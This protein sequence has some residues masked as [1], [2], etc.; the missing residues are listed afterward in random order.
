[1]I[2]GIASDLSS[3]KSLKL[4]PGLNILLAD[5]SA[6]ATDRQ[7]R[8][9]VGKTSLVELVH[10]VLGGKS[11]KENIFRSP[12]LEEWS[13]GLDIDVAAARVTAARRGKKASII[14]ID[15]HASTWP[16]KPS[17]NEYSGFQELENEDWKT[18][19]GHVWFGLPARREN[20]EKARFEPSFRSLFSYFAR[21]QSAG[22]FVDPIRNAEK[23]QSWDQQVSISYLLG[24]DWTISQRLQELRGQERMAGELRKAAKGGELGR[25]FEKAADLRTK[26][27]VAQAKALRLQEQIRSF[28][29]VPQYEA[30][31]REA[32]EL[33]RV[34]SMLSDE[35]VIDRQLVNELRTSLDAEAEPAT[36][37]LAA[38]YDEAGVVLPSAV[39]KRYSDV[40]A[41][42]RAILANRKAHLSAEIQ[43]A[44]ARIA[45]R[46]V[47]QAKHDKRRAE[48]MEILNAGGALDSYI[49]LS[50]EAGRMEA[51]VQ[52]LR[53]RLEAAERLETTKADL[54]V[55]RAQ[56]AQSLKND[57][58]E[59]AEIISEA[60]L[61]FE[62]L[63]DALYEKEGSLTIAESN[64]GPVFEVKI[65][66]QRSKG[67]NNMQIFCF[68]MMLSILGKK[69]NRS[70]GFLIH[71]SHLFD[72]VDERQTARALQI[73]AE[74]SRQDGFQYLVTMNSDAVPK[75]GF[76]RGFRIEDYILPVRLT[77]A[78]DTGG[79]FGTRFE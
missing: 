33:T 59:R 32:S 5:K 50:E 62:W 35:N 78:S 4:R 46:L 61:T 22:G 16:I 29:V 30:L 11:D 56:I 64:N 73:G 25:L 8:N 51:E 60:I 79:L 28:K 71:D 75:E 23:Q 21:R 53:L 67:I 15:G 54:N 38:L 19:L 18:I 6:G 3:F 41:F 77:D 65:E 72:G 9:G 24:L 44:E 27:T 49:R 34:L 45:A 68:D 48:V 63:S 57:V 40:E 52:T 70:P 20:E 76:E 74:R 2:H 43:S 36:F 14:H 12:K 66:S 42:H 10:F 58:H 31:E 17:S 13:F 7:T 37:D 69:R 1:M 55:Q 47:T 39:T 26:L